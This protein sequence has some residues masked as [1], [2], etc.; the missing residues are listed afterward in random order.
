MKKINIENKTFST[1][2]FRKTIEENDV[3]GTPYEAISLS[4]IEIYNHNIAL[5]YS[6]SPDIKNI[7]NNFDIKF[8][9]EQRIFRN[10]NIKRLVEQGNDP[11]TIGKYK[12]I[13]NNK[14]VIIWNFFYERQ[15]EIIMECE[16]L[17]NGDAIKV[18]ESRNGIKCIEP[19][20]Y[21]NIENPLPERI[22]KNSL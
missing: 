3:Q 14:I 1:S 21:Y 2:I 16:I 22:N 15:I 20:I 10:K 17:L 9:E 19:V 4:S 8:T 11:V 6:T 12:I 5:R 13:E 7:N 18:V